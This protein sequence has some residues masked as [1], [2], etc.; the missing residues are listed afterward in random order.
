MAT[1]EPKRTNFNLSVLLNG[2]STGLNVILLFLEAGIASRYVTTDNNGV[3][4]S[5]IAINSFFLV[6][7]DLGLKQGVT[8]Q[9]ASKEDTNKDVLTNSVINFRLL[10][11]SIVAVLLWLSRSFIAGFEG[12]EELNDYLP[13]IIIMLFA[14][15]MDEL[16][17]SL[18]R[19]FQIHTT[20]SALQVVKGIARVV[21]T[22][23]LVFVF[24][25]QLI[26]L[27]I[28]WA[29][30][31]GLP[32]I[33][34]YFI[35]P[36][37][38]SLRIHIP[39]IM[40]LMRFCRPLI[41]VR[42]VAFLRQ[43]A[44]NLIM[45]QLLGPG[46]VAAYSFAF[47]IP[48]GVQSLTEAYNNVFYPRITEMR[49]KKEYEK[50]DTLLNG[51]LAML[52]FAA[53]GIALVGFLFGSEIMT[54]FWSETYADTGPLF[55]I[56]LVGLQ[57]QVVNTFLGYALVGA[58]HPKANSVALVIST[59]FMLVLN[60]ILIII[61]PN[62]LFGPAVGTILEGT[63]LNLVFMG[64]VR[65]YKYILN[66]WHYFGSTFLMIGGIAASFILEWA[67]GISGQPDKTWPLN[68]VI[69]LIYFVGFLQLGTLKMWYSSRELYFV[70]PASN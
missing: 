1:K 50:A 34:A 65:R 23:L 66:Y 19:G 43:S 10:T 14:T 15:S 35:L 64:L 60:F 31:Y 68:F 29:V 18:L 3:F 32:S 2:G 46:A 21:T 69:M 63:A 47:K 33:L 70:G 52:A 8:Q 26:G 5:I 25:L 42:V 37:R 67:L 40:E 11:T 6:F 27:I 44:S 45:L 22:A 20:L 62:G 4:F 61:F 17:F 28:S 51:S 16:M 59:P 24:D 30:S 36:F 56:I 54:L 13:Y 7:A 12:F 53:G 38:K 58:G 41:W 55:G 49:A 57:V 9:I 39:T 48:S